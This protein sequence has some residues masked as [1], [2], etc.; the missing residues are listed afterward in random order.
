MTDRENR[1]EA[2]RQAK[3]T[4]SLAGH[5]GGRRGRLTT[6]WHFA[7][8]HVA[9][10]GPERMVPLN[11]YRLLR[12]LFDALI[13]QNGAD[14]AEA[15]LAYLAHTHAADRVR[16]SRDTHGWGVPWTGTTS[17]DCFQALG[18]TWPCT[19]AAVKHAY[20]TLAPRRTGPGRVIPFSGPGPKR[21]K[22][23]AFWSM[24][25]CR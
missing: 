19:E 5:P 9:P 2:Q 18:L 3:Q 11:R 4:L 7:I 22:R 15:F 25:Q 16:Q 1:S 10:I 12:D 21:M 20:R 14:E 24:D 13:R 8:P 23:P 17:P 6:H